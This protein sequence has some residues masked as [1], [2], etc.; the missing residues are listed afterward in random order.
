MH[1]N[2][3]RLEISINMIASFLVSLD[4]FKKQVNAKKSIKLLMQKINDV[5]VHH[6]KCYVV[7]AKNM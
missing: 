2:V 7:K 5:V 6:K 3:E 4:L 1:T